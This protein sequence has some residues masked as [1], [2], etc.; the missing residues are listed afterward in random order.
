MLL[1]PNNILVLSELH[2][3]TPASVILLRKGSAASGPP[4]HPSP[5]WAAWEHCSG[6]RWGEVGAGSAGEGFPVGIPPL[7]HPGS[8]HMHSHCPDAHPICVHPSGAMGAQLCLA[9]WV[10]SARAHVAG[11]T[12]FPLGSARDGW[13]DGQRRSWNAAQEF[14]LCIGWLLIG[15]PG[16]LLPHN[17]PAPCTSSSAAGGAQVRSL[18]P[19]CP[20]PPVGV[21][22]ALGF[23]WQ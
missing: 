16:V 7:V 20:V 23:A 21:V 17:P 14:L 13:M 6:G 2:T 15:T 11:E 22:T 10:G 4:D 5:S 19:G 9:A 3:E 1:L 18:G 8:P 12:R